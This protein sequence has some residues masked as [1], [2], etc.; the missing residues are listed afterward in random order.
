LPAGQRQGNAIIRRLVGFA[1]ALAL[2]AA[3]MALWEILARLGLLD[4]ASIPPPSR[5]WQAV[6]VM[7]G[8][9]SRL[10][11]TFAWQREYVLLMIPA[12]V[13]FLFS[14]IAGAVL[15]MPLGFSRL[16]RPLRQVF[17]WLA[18][19]LPLLTAVV[20]QIAFSMNSAFPPPLHSYRAGVLLTLDST[21]SGV[22]VDLFS[23]ATAPQPAILWATVFGFAIGLLLGLRLGEKNE[24]DRILSYSSPLWM[25]LLW[26]L[27]S[28]NGWLSPNFFPAPSEVV[29]TLIEMAWRINP[30]TGHLEF[31]E[32]LFSSLRRLAWGTLFGFVPGVTMGLLMGLFPKVRAAGNPLVAMTYPIPKIAILPLLLIIFGLSETSK[33]LVLVIGVFFLVLINTLQGVMQLPQ[34]LFDVANVFKVPNRRR[35]FF[36]I[37]PGAFPFVFAGLR[38]GVGYGLVLIVAAEMLGA[39]TGLGYLIWDSWGLMNIREMYVGLITISALGFVFNA[40]LIRLEQ[41]LAPWAGK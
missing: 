22:Q 28:R 36:I 18:F 3:A 38:L 2:A 12:I 26:E 30:L 4:A 14:L 32:H 39:K 5:F 10:C 6:A 20:W 35:F 13:A 7:S 21:A 11:R 25:V 34:I 16:F 40:L 33:I 41:R 37:L 1:R 8:E 23:I 15:G 24:S 17:R 29:G 19:L 27:A 9:L 31:W